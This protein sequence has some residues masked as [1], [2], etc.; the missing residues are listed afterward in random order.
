MIAI[1]PKLAECA[2][3]KDITRLACLV[4]DYFGEE[5]KYAANL[6][7]HRIYK[8]V[9]IP[10][11]YMDC[12]S[13]G[14]ILAK[15]ELGRFQIQ[16]LLDKSLIDPEEEKLL[17]AH[18]LGHYFLHIQGDVAMG[19]LSLS[20]YR[21]IQLPKERF[22]SHKSEPGHEEIAEREADIFALNLLLPQGMIKKAAIT[23]NNIEKTAKFFGVN[24]L[25]VEKWLNELTATTPNTTSTPSS[26]T[27]ILKGP[28]RQSAPKPI[29]KIEKANRTIANSSYLKQKA[30]Q[31]VS[32]PKKNARAHNDNPTNAL[33]KIRSLAQQIDPTVPK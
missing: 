32:I 15:D 21:E 13:P 10:I 28:A 18:L 9:G 16:C 26:H 2:L 30:T 27:S 7:L 5:Q 23:L 22:L 25:V 4:R 14:T 1:F 24:L 6:N 20:G 3:Q 17:L 29:P 33:T 19:E 31:T 11:S 12:Q 8:N